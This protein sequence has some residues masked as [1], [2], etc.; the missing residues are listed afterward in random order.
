MNDENIVKKT[1]SK[2]T[3]QGKWQIADNI[4]IDCYVTS[5]K[6]RLL[7]LRGTARAMDL[8]GGG[9]GGLLR[10]LKAKWIQ[11]YLSD[12]LRE[13]ILGAETDSISKI[14]AV[15]GPAFIPF[16]A[17]LFV[18][19]C[20]AYIQARNDGILNELKNKTPKT[21][22]GHNTVK[23]HQSL[24]L[25]SG[26][27]HLDKHLVSVIT[28]MK[29]SDNWDDFMYFFNKSYSSNVQLQFNFKD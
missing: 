18:D 10:N 7:S 11:P 26:I 5:D 29:I 23:Y 6:L 12:H 20:K 15:S 9:S 16:E 17:S 28:L 22:K 14:S 24:T 3:H 1:L 19:V 13:W 21:Q 25:D 2:V 4:D 8:K 27:P